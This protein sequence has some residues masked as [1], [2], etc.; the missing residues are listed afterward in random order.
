MHDWYLNIRR[1]LKR[2]MTARELVLKAAELIGLESGCALTIVSTEFPEKR[3]IT[4]IHDQ[5]EITNDQDLKVL[6]DEITTELKHTLQPFELAKFGNA[7][8]RSVVDK[9]FNLNLA[10]ALAIPLVFNDEYLGAI[11]VYFSEPSQIAWDSIREGLDELAEV[12]A[13]SLVK[14]SAAETTPSL[15]SKEIATSPKIPAE[16]T[17]ASD[18]SESRYRRLV[19]HSDAIIF[20]SDP[21][22]KL[23]FVSRRALDFFGMNPEDI[24]GVSRVHWFDFV[25]PDD[26][27]RV[28][29]LAT[30]MRDARSSFDQEFRVI[31]RVSGNVRWL[32]V[33][34]VPVY[35][36]QKLTGW[37]GFG[38]DITSRREAQ[39]SL[40]VQN[41]KIRALYTVSSAI[42]GFLD[43]HNIAERGLVA[44]CD[45]TRA[46]AGL[47]FLFA[48]NVKTKKNFFAAHGFQENLQ[49]NSRVLKNLETAARQVA[50]HGQAL[51]IPDIRLDPRID[52]ILSE[53]ESLH[54][55]LF[56][57]ITVE[58]ETL[59]TICI[60]S[61]KATAFD[62]GDVMLVSS[63]A[64]QIGLAARQANLFTVYRRQTK[65]LAALYRM[66]HELSRNLSTDD[67]FLNAFTIIRD[68]LGL[69]RLWLG[70]VNETGSRIVGQSA[71]GP[72]LRRRLVEVNIEITGANNAIATAV[73]TREP[74]IID[75][76][77]EAR[78]QFGDRKI[79]SRLA[80]SSVVVMPL[81]AGGQVLGVLAVQPSVDDRGFGDDDIT[82]LKSLAN[83]IAAVLLAKRFELRM[84]EGERMRTAGLLAAGIAHNFNNLLQAILG[85]ASLLELQAKVPEKVVR[86]SELITEA[87]TRGAQLV[88]QLMSFAQ[89]ERPERETADLNYILQGIVESLPEQVRAKRTVKIRPGKELPNIYVDPGQLKQV[90]A[91]I[92][93]NAYEATAE[94]G[95]I[96]ISSE[97]VRLDQDSGER[98]LPY[99]QY[100]RISIRDNGAGMDEDTKRRCFEP[101]FT[102]KNLDPGTG[103]SL[104]GN[105]MGL[106]AAYTLMKRN[107][108][109][110]TVESRI[111]IGTEFI[112][113]LPVSEGTSLIPGL[114]AG[115]VLPGSS[116]EDVVKNLAA[117]QNGAKS[118]DNQEL[119]PRS[120]GTTRELR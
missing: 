97:K 47:C 86:A 100:V 20:H 18:E 109:S 105:G 49:T 34:L 71:Y 81:L 103:L 23:T 110:L 114:S 57:P 112:L 79:F 41:R 106:A 1:S 31:N 96:E 120:P 107:G 45:A 3:L 111:G 89:L 13:I 19:E 33:R 84:A 50:T 90:I 16:N 67:I 78:L 102:T 83:E 39:E 65:N 80:I 88:K 42:R 2:R 8:K 91:S 87:A 82:L 52:I 51:A 25:H 55:A 30:E 77:E 94:G 68:E 6:S 117:N 118:K 54:S 69:K 28:K 58:D 43:P 95:V 113:H 98:N 66:S 92:I 59:G 36:N 115:I 76:P 60:F 9:L 24:R 74:V 5:L 4:W 63:A 56:V 26:Q 17:A 10:Q 44:L 64:S 15:R 85:Q 40:V 35:E 99:G 48:P 46:D 119:Q 61:K 93:T 116:A 72:G 104:S 70:L 21:E 53:E 32:F 108:G 11:Q 73:K 7:A 75:K 37:D 38:I 22:Q 101:F 12:M 62:G 14:N 29:T 27:D